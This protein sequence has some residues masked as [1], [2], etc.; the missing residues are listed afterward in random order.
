[1]KKLW[2]VR[3]KNLKLLRLKKPRSLR[4]K[5]FS[6]VW[7]TWFGLGRALN[8]KCWKNRIARLLVIINILD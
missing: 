3:L 5:K 8:S 7:L 4:L 2:L 6:L 1:M